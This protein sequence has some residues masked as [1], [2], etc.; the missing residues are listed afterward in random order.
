MTWATAADV[1]T[2]GTYRDP[3]LPVE[4]RVQDLLARMDRIEKIGQ[5]NQK[6]Y[7]WD[8]YRR[9]GD[10]IEL[11]KVLEDEVK[12]WRGL[13][14]L[15]GLLRADPWSNVTWESGIP[16]ERRVEMVNRVQKMVL[17]HSRWKIPVLF[18][19]EASH[20]YFALGGTILP[21]A[22]GIGSTWN[23]E[24]YQEAARAV[25]GEIRRSGEHLV[26]ISCLDVARDPRW[27]R[28]EECFSED[29]VARS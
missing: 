2:K 6:L 23:P 9:D 26:M 13:G 21:T 18:S 25:V 3:S 1:S 19:T 28:T 12:H 10:R 16:P 29:P 4:Q 27:G 14:A 22:I 5:V 15:Y 11:T 17:Q 20:G 24:L 8:C 7:G